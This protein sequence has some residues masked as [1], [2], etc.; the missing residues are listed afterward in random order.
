MA[1]SSQFDLFSK[2]GKYHH[3]PLKKSLL[4]RI[5]FSLSAGEIHELIPTKEIN[6]LGKSIS[7]PS[8]VVHIADE[9]IPIYRPPTKMRI[10]QTRCP[11][12]QA[13]LD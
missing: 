13:S 1:P 10:K 11:E 12:R 4:R 6:V 9:P 3:H 2:R 7:T 5:V 8:I